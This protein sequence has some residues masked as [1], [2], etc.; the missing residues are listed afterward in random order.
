MDPR[1]GANM[2]QAVN[3]PT[4]DSSRMAALDR[5]TRQLQLRKIAASSGKGMENAPFGASA[6]STFSISTVGQQR[7]SWRD[8]CLEVA[9]IISGTAAANTSATDVN[10]PWCLFG[11]FIAGLTLHINGKAIHSIQLGDYR[12]AFA[13]NMRAR[14][15]VDQLD[16]HSAVL[17]P[18]GSPAFVA[19]QAD[20][21]VGLALVGTPVHATAAP[22]DTITYAIPL[23]ATVAGAGGDLTVDDY[24]ATAAICP[25]TY[26][27]PA[28]TAIRT[29]SLHGSDLRRRFS[30]R[31]H[32]WI[33][34]GN[35]EVNRIVLRVPMGDLIPG[36]YWNVAPAN[37][38]D[39]MLTINWG[40]NS[41]DNA[42]LEPVSTGSHGFVHIISAQMIAADMMQSTTQ[43]LESA[44]EKA[45]RNP[46][47][48]CVVVPA[49]HRRTWTGNDL[50][51]ENQRDV[52]S[53]MLYTTAAGCTSTDGTVHYAS[54]GESFLGAAIEAGANVFSGAVTDPGSYAPDTLQIVVGDRQPYPQEPIQLRSTFGGIARQYNHELM[55]EI[56]RAR[57]ALSNNFMGEP[58]PKHL[59]DSTYNFAW[60]RPYPITGG[61]HRSDNGQVVVRMRGHAPVAV[62]ANA[63][64]VTFCMKAWQIL[65]DRSVVERV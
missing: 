64:V 10:V 34:D 33:D 32:R 28:A 5:D 41:V 2:F 29:G 59:F 21:N 9:F 22:P 44:S 1:I 43:E 8:T 7:L 35:T 45:A 54:I 24:D 36:F 60:I 47:N 48:L 55:Y 18:L 61:I 26:R 38:T 15:T 37:V 11:E 58:I 6:S 39:V 42:W 51:I 27:L 4:Y 30:E 19:P 40:H 13:A 23:N 53:V 56:N 20:S 16:H 3:D 49:I 62:N 46:D 12:E 57:G 17:G 65:A 31:W 25:D 63:I 14:Y 52:Q 50:I